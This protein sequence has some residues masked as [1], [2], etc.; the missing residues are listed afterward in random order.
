MKKVK[1]GV[2]GCGNVSELY[3]KV[4][5]KA[6]EIEVVACGDIIKDKALTIAK[7]FKIPKV[8]N[9]EELLDN[10]EI[11]LIINLT[12]PT[13]HYLITKKAILNR[14]NIFSEKP[15][16]GSFSEV[17]ELTNLAREY[18][19]ILN[20]APDNYL[21]TIVQSANNILHDGILGSIIHVNAVMLSNGPEEWHPNPEFFYM[22]GAGPVLDRGIYY[23]SEMVSLL[24]SVEKVYALSSRA[25]TKRFSKIQSRYFP[26]EVDTH[27]S[28]MLRFRCGTIGTLTTSFDIE[29]HDNDNLLEFLGSKTSMRLPSPM[30]YNGNVLIWNEENMKWERYSSNVMGYDIDEESRGIGAVEMAKDILQRSNRY[31]HTHFLE[32]IYEVVF[33]IEESYRLKKE[34]TIK[35]NLKDK[36][37]YL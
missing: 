28:C 35:S 11:E 36:P 8:Y 5:T 29:T 33:A 31:D 13:K 14:K 18:H 27:V 12:P 2:I 9:V 19:V 21:G 25:L 26:V 30:A 22:R 23:I 32:H 7:E 15:L 4:L 1:V 3:L 16:A 17:L 24:G 10:E 34:I 20:C 37:F 6:P